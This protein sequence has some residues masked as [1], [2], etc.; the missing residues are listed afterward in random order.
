MEM[1]IL[2]FLFI[3]ILVIA[4]FKLLGFFFKAAIFLISIPLQI[5]LFLIVASVLFAVVGPLFGGLVGLGLIIIPLGILA[6]LMPIIL[7]ALGAYLLAHK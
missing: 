6:P 4:G 7:I 1:D 3:L 2:A 5:I